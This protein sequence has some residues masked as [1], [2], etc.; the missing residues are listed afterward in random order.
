MHLLYYRDGVNTTI[1]VDQTGQT[2]FYRSNGQTEASTDPIDMANE[3]LLGHLPMLL[4]PALHDV[5]VLGL[6]TGITASAVARHPVQRIDIVELEPA[7]AQAARLFD[8]ATRKVLDD[9]RVHLTI[10]DGRSRL[11][12]M[13]Q[14]YDVIISDPSDRLGFRHRFTHNTRVLPNRRHAPEGGR[15]LRPM[16]S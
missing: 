2:L 12:G 13:P 11:L 4:H 3:L 5:F 16:G 1:S 8:Y 7:A 9:P 15:H 14:Q 10:G 6:G